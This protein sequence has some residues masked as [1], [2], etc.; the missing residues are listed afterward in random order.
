VPKESVIQ[1]DIL[2]WLNRQRE[3]WAVPY[4]GS[5]YT[6]AGVPDILCCH[7]GIFVALEVKIEGEVPRP[8]QM[9]RMAEIRGAGGWAGVVRSI[10]DAKE[11]LVEARMPPTPA[12]YTGG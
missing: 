2:D 1:A 5:M 12:Q 8:L 4:L 3:T 10:E 7:E 11:A 6:T 9:V